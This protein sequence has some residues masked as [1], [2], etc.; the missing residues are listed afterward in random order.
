MKKI[1]IIALIAV[2]VVGGII[3]IVVFTKNNNGGS[4][5]NNLDLKLD[6]QHMNNKTYSTH[7]NLTAD[8]KITELDEEEPN[9]ARI[10][11]EKENYVIDIT[12]DTEAKEAYNGFQTSAKEEEGYKEVSFGKYSGY[13]AKDDED[14][15]GYILLDESDE[16][17]NVFVN[18][19][20][21]AYD[22][23]VENFDVDAKYNSSNIQNI[24]NQIE[25]KISK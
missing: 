3:A 1:V 15:Y 18:F 25:F 17:F 11:N 19:D 21:Y 10:E 4:S 16:T 7:I 24:L 14:I 2:L 8:D 12:L 22:D 9:S 6:F 23:S 5:K 13:Y 20:V